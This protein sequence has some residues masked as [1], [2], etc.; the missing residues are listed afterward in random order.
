MGQFTGL[1]PAAIAEDNRVAGS[2]DGDVDVNVT[3][4]NY[5]SGVTVDSLRRD[6]SRQRGATP[7]I[8]GLDIDKGVVDGTYT[9]RAGT[10][11]ELVIDGPDLHA[12]GRGPI[13]LNDTGSSN[14]TLHLDTPSLDRLARIV[15]RE[16]LRGAAIVDGTVTG[17]GRELKAQ[18]TLTAATSDTAR[19]ARSTSTARST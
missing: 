12:N 7:P 2:V 18:G 9:N 17:N 8:G 1:D 10:L 6:R 4:R 19:T 5:V 3:L 14:L 11:N 16:G 13:A 15:G